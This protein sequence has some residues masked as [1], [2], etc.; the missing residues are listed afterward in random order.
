M[1]NVDAYMSRSLYTYNYHVDCG[2][3]KRIL[4]LINNRSMKKQDVTGSR[5]DFELFSVV[6]KVPLVLLSLYVFVYENIFMHNIIA[7]SLSP[8]GLVNI[9]DVT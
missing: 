7:A 9:S 8:L 2:H 6:R 1:F 3:Y 5:Y 4:I